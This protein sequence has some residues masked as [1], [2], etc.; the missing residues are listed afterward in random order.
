M[1]N[2]YCTVSDLANVPGA[3]QSAAESFMLGLI[4]MAS[5]WI[6]N[7][8][9]RH[10]YTESGVRYFPSKS[11]ETFIDDVLAISA[12][13]VDSEA[14]A[15]FDG[16]T[17]TE[18]T[19]YRLLPLNS[20]PKCAMETLPD[21]DTAL[22]N[23]GGAYHLK[24]TGTWGYGD[25]SSGSPWKLSAVTGTVATTDGTTLT[26][27]AS[28]TIVAGQTLKIG[29]EQLFVSAVSGTDATVERGVNGTTTAAHDTDAIY[30]ATYPE[31]IKLAAL[32]KTLDFWHEFGRSGEAASEWMGG[33]NYMRMTQA[34]ATARDRRMVGPYIRY[35]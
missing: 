22:G 4:E 14:D 29:D 30:T 19:D 23:S 5:R 15:T 21:A 33:F 11:R 28:G 8:A 20:W 34:E 24:I 9:R 31:T 27:S 12:V 18:G 32:N 7:T 13:G 17:M 6:D 26:L 1:K 35:V 2:L 16:D 25:G 3:H 10:F